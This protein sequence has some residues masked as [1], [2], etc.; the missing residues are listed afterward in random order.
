MRVFA[1]QRMR[2]DRISDKCS[3]AKP[4]GGIWER[5]IR[6][7]RNVLN[8]LLDDHGTQLDEESLR[9][10][11][12]ETESIVN[13]QPLT[14]ED[15]LV[16]EVKIIVGYSSLTKDG[17]RVRVTTVLER[18]IQKLVLLLKSEGSLTKN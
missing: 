12:C 2:L 16:R 9:T 13:N 4:H 7:L 18:P 10:F 6:T 15:G 3:L 14:G 8:A 1:Q 11:M 17:K 5:Q